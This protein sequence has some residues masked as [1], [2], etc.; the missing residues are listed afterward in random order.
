MSW[1]ERSVQ[2]HRRRT[3]CAIHRAYAQLASDPITSE[4]FQQ[5]LLCARMRA[6]QLFSAPITN[7]RHLGVDALLNLARFHEVHLRPVHA[8]QEAPLSW[9]PAI[10]SLAHHLTGR[11]PIP[12]FMASVWHATDAFADSR[13]SWVIAH[14]GGAS[15][16]SLPLPIVMTRKMEHIFLAS[17]HHLPLTT[18][19]RRAE[20][21]ALG[22][23]TRLVAAVLATRLTTDLRNGD[24]WRS[25]WLF[26]IMHAQEIDPAQIGPIIDYI[27]A[28]RHDHIQVETQDGT[29]Q[30]GPP[31]P[32]FSMKGRTVPSLLRLMQEWH[33]SLG[34][35]CNDAGYAWMRSSFKPLVIEEP[36]HDETKPPLRWQMVELTSS[37]HLRE[38]GI[39]M[40]HCVGSYAH[41]CHRGKSSIWSLRIWNGETI[42]PVLTV[43]VDPKDRAIVQAR[44]KANKA[45]SGKPR[46]IL[47]QWA[48]REGLQMAV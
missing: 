23:P 12:A 27:Q 34:S 5:L 22:M 17:Q 7:G 15:F 8:W 40:H 38:E 44:A 30:I 1:S 36:R 21:I 6:K 41:L 28:V 43:E 18:A 3:D 29:M 11:Y 24:F 45:P 16:R 33:R 35:T 14:A 25:V 9:R 26:F 32:A 47:H 39:A 2:D 48:A 31:Q 37:A 10:A 20:L 46:R 13:R 19:I 42:R 4:T